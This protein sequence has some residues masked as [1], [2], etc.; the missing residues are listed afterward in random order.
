MQLSMRLL[1]GLAIVATALSA[2]TWTKQLSILSTTTETCSCDGCINPFWE[3]ANP[4]LTTDT[5][6]HLGYLHHWNFR[7]C[8]SSSV[9]TLTKQNC[10][11]MC[12]QDSH[13]I[14]KHPGNTY[15]RS[16]FLTHGA[17]VIGNASGD[18]RMD[19]KFALFG[20]SSFLAD[21]CSSQ[22]VRREPRL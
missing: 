1:V 2:P 6:P 12:T 20:T 18:A 14:A 10:F 13:N 4:P 5:V 19:C 21:A 8:S 3:S 16:I 9:Q 17:G 15:N 7:T 11:D 22:A